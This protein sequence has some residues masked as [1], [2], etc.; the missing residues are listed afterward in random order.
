MLS[1]FRFVGDLPLMKVLRAFLRSPRPRHLRELCSV[2]ELSPGGVSDILRRL[3]EAGVLKRSA[4]GNRK[5]HT[6]RLDEQEQKVF[7]E[8]FSL[9]EKIA[10]QERAQEFGKHAPAKLEWMDEAYSFFKQVKGKEV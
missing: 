9:Y 2:C 8:L 1:L 4:H 5:Y 7:E 10:M 3:D 6:L